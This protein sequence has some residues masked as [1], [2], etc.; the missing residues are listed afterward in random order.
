VFTHEV[1]LENGIV[2]LVLPAKEGPVYYH[3]IG[4]DRCRMNATVKNDV[5]PAPDQFFG[6]ILPNGE[7]NVPKTANVITKR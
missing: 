1:T 6:R 4:Q 2:Y 7:L 3:R 5:Y